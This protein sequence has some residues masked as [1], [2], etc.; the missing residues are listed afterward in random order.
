MAETAEDR[1][2]RL[3]QEVLNGQRDLNDVRRSADM[4]AGR[5]PGDYSGTNNDAMRLAGG[6]AGVEQAIRDIFGNRNVPL[7]ATTDNPTGAPTTPKKDEATGSAEGIIRR[8]LSEFD[9]EGLAEWAWSYYKETG[10]VDLLMLELR[11]RPEYAARFPGLGSLRDK[12]RAISENEYIQTERSIIQLFKAN[13]MPLDVFGTRDFLGRIIGAEVSP[14]EVADRVG[15]LEA[16]IG[17]LTS[18]P[19]VQAELEAFERFYG[20]RPTFGDLAALALNTDEALPALQRKF[21]AVRNERAAGRAGYGDLSR[22][23]AERL[24]DLGVTEEQATEGF[25]A[26]AANRELFTALPGG[27][28]DEI[29]RED[30]MGAA[31]GGNQFARERIERRRRQRQGSFGGGGGFTSSNEGLTG[32]GTAR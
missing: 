21:T 8:M 18:N 6:A 20:V 10:S 14:A 11:K 19:E 29:G 31:F 16:D 22:L 15:L 2:F 30:Q 1:I 13:A 32:L 3:T 28:E 24:A 7:T 26:L 4:L 17:R 12:G 5:S 23:E 25:G 27:R 9:L